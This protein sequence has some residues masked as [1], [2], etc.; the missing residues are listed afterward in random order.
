VSAEIVT[1]ERPPF[2]TRWFVEAVSLD[3]R[4]LAFLRIG[5]GLLL[6]WDWI[7]HLSVLAAL[8]TD[9]GVLSRV[10]RKQLEYDF[11]EPWWMSL[12]ML[13]GSLW[14]QQ[15]LCG[16][17]IVAAG[18]VLVGYRTKWALVLSHFL[19]LG[20]HGRF[21]LLTQGGDVLFRCMIFWALFLPLDERWSVTKAE[22]RYGRVFSLATAGLIVQLC[23]MYLFTAFLKTGSS[24]R[25]EFSAA[26]YALGHGQFTNA[27]GEWAMQFPQLL[28]VATASTLVLE[29]LVPLLLFS[30]IAPQTIRWL[31]PPLML[32]FHFGLAMFMTLGTFHWI[33]AVYWLCLLPTPAWDRVEGW[34]ATRPADRDSQTRSTGIGSWANNTL[35]GFFI[36]Y[37]VLLNV[38]RL[39][40]RVALV[41]RFPLCYVG[42]ALGI[43]QYWVMFAPQPF[44][45]A[46]WL[47]L[48]G[49]R[50]DGQIVNL[51]EPG[52][53]FLEELP[54]AMGTRYPNQYWRRCTCMLF[55]YY[56]TAHLEGFASYFARQW[57]ATHSGV[58]RVHRIRV[59]CMKQPTPPP[60]SV[61]T[62][63]LVTAETVMVVSL[64][65]P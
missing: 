58:E 17:A 47:R 29:F 56:E 42:K 10:A 63:P 59:I 27:I 60:G 32:L 15:L 44:M 37:I 65:E 25:T 55:E 11:D 20:L 31:L 52:M 16:I 49:E 62:P 7:A 2:L 53:P 6:L 14:W 51:H 8:F 30:P 43:D 28:S 57:N 39:Q 40:N 45:Q 34:F 64:V 13:N 22:R 23:C 50:L 26:Y 61:P 46:Q 21:P 9:D 36:L 3:V 33:C 38:S 5:I 18:M 24:W 4:G 1:L 19:L 48:E 35:A 12:H 41:G 54:R